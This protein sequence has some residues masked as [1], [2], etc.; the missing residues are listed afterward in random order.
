M[1]VLKVFK[2][3]IVLMVLAVPAVSIAASPPDSERLGRAKDFIADERWQRAIAELRGVVA[4]QK[5]SARD[6]AEFWL[7]HS[8][9]QV[10]DPAE[11]LEVIETLEREFPRSRWVKPARSLRIEIAHRL[12]R[13]DLLWRVAAPP[14][15]AL[16]PPA[17]ATPV[18][19]PPPTPAPSKTRPPLISKRPSAVVPPERIELPK[20]TIDVDGDLRLLALSGLMATDAAR[21]IPILRDIALKAEDEAQARRAILVL[22]QS[23][24]KDARS[25]IVEVARSGDEIRQTAAVKVLAY[26]GWPE[27]EQVL[28]DIY[29]ASTPHVKRQVIRAFGSAGARFQ[30]RLLFEGSKDADLKLAIVNALFEAGARSELERIAKSD[31]DEE[32]RKAANAK[33]KRL[34]S[35]R[36]APGGSSVRA[37]ALAFAAAR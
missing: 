24:R 21:V 7:A 25:T 37:P 1:R 19:V 30:L 35:T 2:V 9:N 13:T 17:A 15:A 4:D 16:P 10:G 36:S 11:A 32:I 8:L 20:I 26:Q 18:V 22:A 27:A 5:E 3:L 33:L 28:L 34:R 14:S 23:D 6:E 31:G 29:G 12:Q